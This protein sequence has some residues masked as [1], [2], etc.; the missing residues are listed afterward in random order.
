MLALYLFLEVA[1]ARPRI[2]KVTRHQG[3]RPAMICCD[4]LSIS[5]YSLVM[6]RSSHQEVNTVQQEQDRNLTAGWDVSAVDSE[7]N[8]RPTA[9]LHTRHNQ[10]TSNQ[11]R[12]VKKELFKIQTS[13]DKCESTSLKG[14][15]SD[16]QQCYCMITFSFFCRKVNL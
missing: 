4:G 1:A 2:I 10:H 5:H 7:R 15:A 14:N 12:Q 3:L 16:K 9:V 11:R 13:T 8:P 6:C